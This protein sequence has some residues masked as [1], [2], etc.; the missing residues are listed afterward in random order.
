MDGPVCIFTRLAP[1]RSGRTL[2]FSNALRFFTFEQESWSDSKPVGAINFLRG[3]FS[4]RVL[5]SLGAYRS[6]GGWYVRHATSA[7]PFLVRRL[8]GGA[9]VHLVSPSPFAR[10]D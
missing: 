8:Y 9:Y 3:V 6:S 10:V 1:R 7:C 5:R 2:E 4:Y